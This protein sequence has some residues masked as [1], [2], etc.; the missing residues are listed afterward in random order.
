MEF[1]KKQTVGV[2]IWILSI[3]LLLNLAIIGAGAHH[4]EKKLLASIQRL[5]LVELPSLRTQMTIDMMHDGLTGVVYKSIIAGED[6]NAEDLK[7]VRAE[8][9]DVKK[10][11]EESFAA[12]KTMELQKDVIEKQQIAEPAVTAYLASADE[13]IS[14]V[15]KGKLSEAKQKLPEFQKAF[16]E[17][18]E[19]LGQFGDT[20]QSGGVAYGKEATEFADR[21]I[22]FT[23]TVVSF[24]MVVGLLFAWMLTRGLLSSLRA[25]VSG[26][27]S[28]ST[29]VTEASNQSRKR[30]EELSA[31]STEQSTA[32]QETA[33]SLEEINAMLKRTSEN[34]KNLNSSSIKSSESATQGQKSV[35]DVLGAMNAI[36]DSNTQIRAQVEQSNKKITDIV[37]VISEIGQ[38][39]KVINDIV[40][41]TK[42]LSFNASVEAARAGEHGKGFAVVA[43]EVGNLAQMS[44]NAAKE[45]SDMLSS[46]IS[47]VEGIVEETKRS[48]EGLVVEGKSKVDFGVQTAKR[49]GES[50][51]EIVNQVEAV[52]SMVNDIASAIG[53]QTQGIGEIS[54]AISQLDEATQVNSH[55][56]EKTTSE[57]VKL[58]GRVQSLGTIVN[59]LENMIIQNAS[60]NR[61]VPPPVDTVKAP[62]AVKMESFKRPQKSEVSAT[63]AKPQ[64][65]Q[66]KAVGAEDYETV[67]NSDD[68]RFQDV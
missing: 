13:V 68:P 16:D 66:P 8:F 19:L 63:H 60:A 9:G 38:K 40:F 49:C 59:Q 32:I 21:T 67:P 3:F 27:K 2:K 64:E 10:T 39:T 26:L 14:L 51:D 11:F 35:R 62:K 31:S 42:L 52:K 28:E 23:F 43:E 48:I 33:A 12:L 17:L 1:Y 45:I 30:A 65:K 41:Q 5:T 55:L 6:S 58:S 36:Q 47:K 44:G 25:A 20:I 53:E 56:A 54:K 24:S 34:A 61:K 18:E 15:E 50:L 37:T 29:Q 22:F 4:G 57:S 46:S 7:I